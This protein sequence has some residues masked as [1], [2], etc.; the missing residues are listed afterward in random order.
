[1]VEPTG[2]I[3]VED[4][5]SHWAENSPTQ[6]QVN[7]RLFREQPVAGVVGAG[8]HHAVGVEVSDE[9]AEAV[10]LELLSQAFAGTDQADFVGLP[11]DAHEALYPL[12]VD[13][14]V[15]QPQED[16]HSAAA[17][18]R[19]TCVL[20]VDKPAQ[21]QVKL[22]HRTIARHRGVRS[23]ARHVGELTL[24]YDANIREG[25]Q[26]QKRLAPRE[27]SR[28]SSCEAM[29]TPSIP[30]TL[31][32]WPVANSAPSHRRRTMA[33]V[34]L[35]QGYYATSSSTFFKSGSKE[36]TR[37]ASLSPSFRSLSSSRT[38]PTAP[39]SSSTKAPNRAIE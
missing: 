24:T 38:S 31:P 16:Q 8:G 17:V 5:P 18:E 7:S 9:A 32:G 39:L 19:M 10:V 12:S 36:T 35:G 14:I 37:R 15:L 4:C 33:R 34:P 23:G 28:E 30:Q 1:M 22:T 29:P 6:A 20:F 11:H 21:L 25:G 2:R 27:S 26:A 13:D 3:A